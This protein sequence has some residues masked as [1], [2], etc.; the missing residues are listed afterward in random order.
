MPNRILRRLVDVTTVAAALLPLS[1][2][3]QN[4][5]SGQDVVLAAGEEAPKDHVKARVYLPVDRL[6]AGASTR[7]AVVLEVE[8]GW[9]INANP[10]GP[11]FAIPT[12]VAV[13]AKH[14]TQAAGGVDFPKGGELAVEYL[15]EPLKV[16]EGRVVLFG[17]LAVP[18]AAA[19]QIEE[20]T[21]EVRFQACN[22]QQCLPPKTAKLTGKIPVAPAGEKV[23]AI[24]EDLFKADQAKKEKKDGRSAA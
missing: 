1:L 19:R 13:K 11:K 12:T 16:Y 3:A 21:V 9:H 4:A 15:D 24:N 5:K 18:P 10:A 8:N 23:K 7:F 6:S 22:D 20:V 17:T 14:G 2:Y